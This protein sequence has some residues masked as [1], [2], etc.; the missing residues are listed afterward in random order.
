[1]TTEPQVVILMGS[2]SDE[3]VMAKAAEVLSKFDVSHEE[4][5]MSAHRLP[6]P[7]AEY[8]TQAKSKG[9]KIFIAGAGLAAHLAGAVAAHTTLPV[10]GVPLDSGKGLGGLDAL[11]ST[12][13][14][15]KGVPVATVAIDGAA[16][17]AFLAIQILSLQDEAL[18]ERFE[19]Y[20]SVQA[21]KLLRN[22]G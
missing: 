12:M 3:E 22:T 2:Q 11:L 1:M 20:R 13:Q 10:I 17:A 16:N 4:K 21:G 5:I 18:A 7:V 8:A 9:V 6:E 15:P 19:H 14:M